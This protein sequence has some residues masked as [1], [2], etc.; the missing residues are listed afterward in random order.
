[1]IEKIDEILKRNQYEKIPSQDEFLSLYVQF[2]FSYAQA[3]QIIDADNASDIVNE[4]NVTLWKDD[5]K[6][7]V[8]EQGY[9][10][11]RFLTIIVSNR[12]E[13]YKDIAMEDSECWIMDGYTS[14][15]FIYENQDVDFDS[16]RISID[17]LA[18]RDDPLESSDFEAT[19]YTNQ[20]A[21]AKAKATMAMSHSEYR[22]P[23]S[24]SFSI[25]ELA[26]SLTVVNT[27]LIIINVVIF[28]ALSSKG[29][30]LD[31]DFMFEKGAMYV[32]AVLEDHQFYRLFSC[33]FMHFGFSHLFGNMLVLYLLGGQVEGEMGSVK[34]AVLY[35]GGGLFGSVG[36]FLHTLIWKENVVSAGAS[37]AI[38]AVMGALLWLV[39]QNR[40]R[41]NKM[42]T[43]KV[44]VLFIYELYSGFVNPQID[45]AAHLFGFIGGF[46]LAMLLYRQDAEIVDY[47]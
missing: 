39:V 33:M 30:T 31:V 36:S 23:R 28:F 14:R 10:D 19:E 8:V 42:T 45:M 18:G 38:F 46:G 29:S 35:L 37:G 26:G 17:Q 27:A 6:E 13:H 1:M 21:Y 40:G 3:V 16:L 4:E 12:P 15:L 44:V 47:L 25:S 22:S 34:Y 11:I 24:S 32:P 41:L 20:Q 2:L 9:D 43:T 5:A 7:Y